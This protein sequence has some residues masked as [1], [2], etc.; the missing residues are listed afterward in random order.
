MDIVR[1]SWLRLFALLSLMVVVT[2]CAHAQS[3]DDIIRINTSLVQ[4]NVGVVDRQG[5]AVTDLSRLIPRRSRPLSQKEAAHY[6]SYSMPPI[7]RELPSTH[8]RFPQVIPSACR[9]RRRN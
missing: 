1:K 8:L 6:L 3:D 4:L 2:Q 9:C 7:A 5:R